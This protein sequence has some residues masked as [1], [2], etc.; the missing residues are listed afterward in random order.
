MPAAV[1]PFRS[2]KQAAWW[3]L[4]LA[5][6]GRPAEP[7]GILLADEENRLSV[8]LRQTAELEDLDEQEEDV[9]GSLQQDLVLRAAE[10]GA[11]ELLAQLE[12]SLSHF[13]LISD[14]T[15]AA[16]TGDASRLLERLF[17]EHVG[18]LVQ[19]FVTHLPLYSIQAAAT[20]FGE[21]TTGEEEGWVRAPAHLRLSPDMFVARVVGRSMEPLIPDGSL[22]IFRANVTGTR[23]GRRLLIEQFGQTGEANRYTVKKYSS[24]KRLSDEGWEHERILLTPL[25]AEFEAFELGPDGFRVL[26]EF[27]AVVDPA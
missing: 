2:T 23:Q 9:L 7:L 11:R 3:L 13:L 8:K 18:E 5:R 14:R 26:G 17:A 19:P 4:E 24:S 6:P 27:V 12:N 21:E 15:A 20:R 1:I 16:Y 25:N 22:C 10:A